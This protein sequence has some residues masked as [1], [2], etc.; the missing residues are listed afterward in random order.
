MGVKVSLK[1]LSSAGLMLQDLVHLALWV[2]VQDKVRH[3]WILKLVFQFSAEAQSPPTTHI[4]SPNKTSTPA[5]IPSKARHL[6]QSGLLRM[7]KCLTL[8]QHHPPP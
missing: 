4:Y 7:A 6:L 1:W 2:P 5:A 8:P 3:E